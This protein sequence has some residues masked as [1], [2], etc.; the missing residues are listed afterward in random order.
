MNPDLFK[1][2][3]STEELCAK[4]TDLLELDDYHRAK[5][6]LSRCFINYYR[7]RSWLEL[8]LTDFVMIDDEYRVLMINIL[9]ARY[10]GLWDEEAL[11]DLEKR[12]ISYLKRKELI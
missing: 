2:H 5:Q 9:M 7:T 10:T 1:F 8:D 3:I 6:F 12:C 4:M 11:F